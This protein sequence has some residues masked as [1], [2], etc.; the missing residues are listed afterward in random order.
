MGLKHLDLSNN[1][2]QDAIPPSWALPSAGLLAVTLQTLLL[3]SNQLV[4]QLPDMTGMA[5]LSCWSVANN[6]LICG[7][8]PPSG[9][10]GN[11]NGTKIGEHVGS[12]GHLAFSCG[13]VANL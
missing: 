2:L 11:V 9:T 1:K 3:N 12:A 10:C 13:A 8:Q 4:G 5:A 6:W 7:P